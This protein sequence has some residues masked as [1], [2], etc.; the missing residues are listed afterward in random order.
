MRKKSVRNATQVFEAE[1]DAIESF[2]TEC[3]KL[4]KQHSSSAYDFGVIR[5]YRAFERLMLEVLVGVMNNDT[6]TVSAAIGVP[7]PKHLTDEVCQY[8]VIGTGYF[9]FK[10]RD[11]LL[12]LLQ[13]FLPADHWLVTTAKKAAYRRA[14]EQLAALRNFAAHSSTRAKTGAKSATGQQ[15]ISSAGA[16]LKR[17]NRF[18]TMVK[19]LR[20]FARDIAQSAPR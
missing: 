18:S 11:G 12:Q 10:G 14:L 1:L 5:L 7:L 13:R 19:T 16:W 17:Q 3:A 4:S 15:R 6:S 8:F 2:L 9:D 20:L